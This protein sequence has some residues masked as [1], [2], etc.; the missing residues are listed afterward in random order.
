M[1]ETGVTLLWIALFDASHDVYLSDIVS[2]F[3]QAGD[4]KHL[5][6]T[7]KTGVRDTR[8][9]GGELKGVAGSAGVLRK[10]WRKV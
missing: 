6:E 2:N 4:N 10:T 1:A 9:S 7:G 5:S 8:R 3:R